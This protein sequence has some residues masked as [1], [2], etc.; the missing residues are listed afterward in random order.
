MGKWSERER[1]R[2][3]SCDVVGLGGSS[4]FQ[5]SIHADIATPF[6]L[7]EAFW[8]CI[9]SG[10]VL[11]LLLKVERERGIAQSVCE[12]RQVYTTL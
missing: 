3:P 11:L 1:E 9:Y 4:Q 5:E 6:A 8:R 12:G 2:P 7:E 10:V